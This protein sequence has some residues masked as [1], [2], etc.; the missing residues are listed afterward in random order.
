M[1]WLE[2]REFIMLLSGATAAWPVAA[3]AQQP[4]KVPTVGLLV[5]STPS[6]H[7]QLFAALVQRL[8]ELGWIENR[9]VAI[10]Y[11]FA[12]GR[13]TRFAEIAAEFVRMKV[14]VIVTTGAA[15][16]EAKHATSV[17][18]IVFTVAS[19][20]VGSGFVASLARPG[21]N[22]T[23][24][25]LQTTD[26]A[27][28]RLELLREVVPGLGELAVMGNSGF[29]AVMLEMRELETT[30]RTLGL[31]IVTLGMG[32]AE[33]IVPAFEA[34]KGRVQALYVCADSTTATNRIRIITL[35]QGARLP[36]MFTSRQEVEAGGLMS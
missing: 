12:E 10:L 5:P 25:S 14:D 29:V 1:V 36:T 23:G 31:K 8:R 7:G 26:L 9:S 17:I 16:H 24:L 15:I 27:S 20:P 2:R 4:A 34:L 19:D 6:S 32:G 35:A 11:R 21:G 28:K 18:P 3:G 13:D 30:A 33:D 22:V